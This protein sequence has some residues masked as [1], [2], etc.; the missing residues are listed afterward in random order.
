LGSAKL[1]Q[2]ENEQGRK[3]ERLWKSAFERQ[4]EFIMKRFQT[5][6]HNLSSGKPKPPAILKFNVSQ[7]C[8]PFGQS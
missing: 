6:T 4:K 8:S 1:P 5:R 7:S 3:G 2:E